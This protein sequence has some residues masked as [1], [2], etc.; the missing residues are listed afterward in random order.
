[1][2][3]K[4]TETEGMKSMKAYSQNERSEPHDYCSCVYRHR[5][6]R[7]IILKN[8]KAFLTGLKDE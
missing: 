7:V 5:T 1:M 4:Y 2:K 8:G 3:K 6:I